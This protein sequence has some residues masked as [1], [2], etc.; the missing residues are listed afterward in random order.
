MTVHALGLESGVTTLQMHRQ[1]L[2]GLTTQ[3]GTS[4]PFS[5]LSGLYRGCPISYTAVTTM[6]ISI[7]PVMAWIKGTSSTTQGGY[8]FISD[9]ATTITFTDGNASTARTDKI[10]ARVQDNTYDGGGVTAASIAYWP[11]DLTTGVATA[12]P[13]SCLELYSV[14]VPA[15]ASIGTGGITWST[16][17]TAT[18]I[19]TAASG[20]VIDCNTAAK[21]TAMVAKTPPSGTLIWRDDQGWFEYVRS[22]V[23]RPLTVPINS[24]VASLPSYMMYPA[25]GSCAFTNDLH[26]LSRYTGSAWVPVINVPM[27]VLSHTVATA[28]PA[29]IPWNSEILDPLNW[30]TGSP[31]MT[32]VLPTIAGWYEV[33]TKWSINVSTQRRMVTLAHKNGAL[34]AGS[35]HAGVSGV[36]S[37]QSSTMFT[38]PPVYLNGTTDYISINVSTNY[39]GDLLDISTIGLRPSLTVKLIRVD[40]T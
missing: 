4:S 40:Q 31:D 36:V 23:N 15:G 38:P 30:H 11:G 34:W 27:C 6:S 37:Q 7:S 20:G 24:T 25:T 8:P 21:T 1:S 28:T 17:L 33:T 9:A 16:A 12:L 29:Y 2:E 26:V 35:E 32:R 10:I 14:V 39:G 3:V 22:G 18:Y 5:G 19:Y 13:D